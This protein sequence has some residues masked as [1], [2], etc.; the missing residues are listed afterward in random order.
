[1][2]QA[3]LNVRI[4]SE[5]KSR[6]EK[7]CKQTGLNISTCIN[8]FVKAVLREQRLPFEVKADTLHDKGNTPK[9]Q[10]EDSKRVPSEIN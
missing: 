7:F 10:T 6:F 5:D 1:M 2:S 8:M 3:M 4:S 9:N